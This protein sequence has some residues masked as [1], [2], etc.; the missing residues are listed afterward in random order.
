MKNDLKAA[1]KEKLSPEELALVYKSYD[2]IGDIAVIRVPEQLLP[3]SE[4]I[5][6]A[7]MQQH[8]HV[9]AVWQQSSPVSGD[10]RLRKLEWVA[11]EKKTETIHKEHGCLFKVDI[12]EC[13]FSPRLAFERMRI[14]NLVEDNEVVVNMF[15]GV[16]CYSIIIAKHSKA[17]KVY[18]IDINPVAVRYVRE[19]VLL[20]KVIDKVMPIEGNARTII[21]RTLK[22]MADRVL[23]P[24][25]ERAYEYLDSAF[26][27]VKPQ[28]GW[29][30]YYD[31]EHAGKEEDPIEKVKAKVEE[32]LQQQ[33]VN[34]ELSFSRIVRQTGPNWYQIAIDIQV[35]K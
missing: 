27:A 18:S 7:L 30:H 9:K 12:K 17:T 28:G 10:F 22:N 5:A 24:L 19:N 15:A 23:M 8:K 33:K 32:K 1:L 20:N 35:N 25:P 6:E 13:Y 14:A 21:E 11:G 34:F 26:S 4:T 16:G 2:V 31:F 29:I 3:L